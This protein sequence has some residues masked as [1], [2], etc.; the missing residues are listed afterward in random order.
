MFLSYLRAD[1]TLTKTVEGTACF[2]QDFLTTGVDLT[3]DGSAELLCY[4]ETPWQSWVS[5]KVPAD[6]PGG[7]GFIALAIPGPEIHG[8][9][10][11]YTLALGIGGSGGGSIVAVAGQSHRL[12]GLIRFG[13]DSLDLGHARRIGN[14]GSD[15]HRTACQGGHNSF[16]SYRRKDCQEGAIYDTRFGR[17]SGV[18]DREDS[19]GLAKKRLMRYCLI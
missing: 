18:I 14:C 17:R 10:G 6:T 2:W 13:E 12:R 4:S 8:V 5:V 16:I 3:G 11:G 1:G 7:R 15:V 9:G 19:S